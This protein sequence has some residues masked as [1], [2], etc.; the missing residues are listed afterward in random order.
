MRFLHTSDWH[1]GRTLHGADLSDA[2]RLWTD[3]VVE[4]AS[5]QSLDAVLISG[6]VYDRGIPTV[7]MV[8]LLSDTLERLLEHTQVVLTPGNHDSAKRLGFLAS[9]TRPGLHIVADSRRASEPVRITRG[10]EVVGLVYALPYLDPDTERRRLSDTGEPLARSHSAVIGGVL[11]RISHNLY[12][13]ELPDVPRVVMAHAFVAGGDPSESER[14]IHI[15][16]VDSVPSSLFRLNAADANDRGAI[17]YVALGH[18]H[19][20][21]RVGRDIDPVMRYSGSPIPFSFSE[22]NHRKSSVLVEISQSGAKPTIELMPVPTHRKLA[23]LKDAFANLISAEYAQYT[24]HY[25]RIYVTDEVR[26]EHM[27]ARLRQHFPYLLETQHL[28]PASTEQIAS[29]EQIREQPIEALRE[30]FSS[31]GGRELTAEEDQLMR[32]TW[33]S[34]RGVER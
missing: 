31:A 12:L 6:D 17:D 18:L 1:L 19:G 30:F 2:F 25:V 29:V 28:A 8:D 33:E 24:D 9:L 23:T 14:D 20:P 21:Q 10:N 22:E 13:A 11:D 26:P 15:G 4:L 3:H 34:I 32:D 27:V 5:T 16:G 7:E